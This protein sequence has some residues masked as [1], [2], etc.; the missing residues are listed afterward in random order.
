[1][2]PYI[3]EFILKNWESLKLG[4]R[5]KDLLFIKFEDRLI[6]SQDVSIITFLVKK[7]TNNGETP[8]L[9]VK[10]PRYPENQYAN[11]TLE[12][13]YNNL[14]KVQEN[15]DDQNILNAMPNPILMKKIN[16]SIVFISNHLL[17]NEMGYS[18]FSKNIDSAF[19]DNFN[20]SFKWL[21]N[22]QN[23]WTNKFMITFKE[24]TD[25][26]VKA[27]I[28]KYCT[29]FPNRAN[30][31][32]KY[33]DAILHK[34]SEF[35]NEE[36]IILPQHGDFHASN[37]FITNNKISGVIDFED[38]TENG[39]PCFDLIHFISSYFEALFDYSANIGYGKGIELLTCNS[40]WK[41]I[42]EICIKKYCKTLT[43][44]INML[45][46]FI[47]LFLIESICIAASPRK[48]AR[49]IIPKKE[50]ILSLHPFTVHE[51]LS[52]MAIPYYYLPKKKA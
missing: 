34:C 6:R 44:N 50:M 9:I 7:I 37:L 52:D 4:Q 11:L 17:G 5:P 1:M 20:M 45:A 27:I 16:N 15:I 35:S 40:Q 25:K 14:I 38:F 2:I 18:I 42:I 33:F 24:F 43:I 49:Y 32:D 10:I 13:E 29:T 31:H 26:Y 36:I 8:F 41:E 30:S 3:K 51:L 28:Q 47:P 39:I 19:L 48:K 23:L 22:F 21:V 46:I 12:N